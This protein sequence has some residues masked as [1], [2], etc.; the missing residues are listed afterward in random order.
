MI[1][2]MTSVGSGLCPAGTLDAALADAPAGFGI[3]ALDCAGSGAALEVGGRWSGFTI[4]DGTGK[5]SILK[6]GSNP[7]GS[8][9]ESS[10]QLRLTQAAVARRLGADG[11]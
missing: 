11:A 4:W 2:S 7:S 3:E 9:C 1:S 6:P 10:E 5:P 8:G